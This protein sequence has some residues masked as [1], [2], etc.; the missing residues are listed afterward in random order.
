MKWDN[1]RTG[2]LILFLLPV[3]FGSLFYALKIGVFQISNEELLSFFYYYIFDVHTLE[4]DA[5]MN[6]FQYDVIMELRLP[7][8]IMAVIAGAGLAAGGVVM[9]ALVRNP[10]ADP[11]VLGVSSGA[12][13]GA[14]MGIVLGSFAFFGSFAVSVGAFLGAL[15]SVVLVFVLSFGGGRNTSVKMVL[16]GMAVNAIFGAGTSL[17]VYLAK[18]AEGIRNAVFWM[19]GSLS[20]ASWDLIPVAA[21]ITVV[22]CLLFCTQFRVLNAS[23]LGDEMAGIL[24]I[25][26]LT[27]RK[28][29]LFI[30]SLQV[31]VLVS[32]TG[33]IGFVGL[34][35]PHIVRML[36]GANHSR[37]L[38]LS[39]LLGAI[40]MIWC[41]VIARTALFQAELPI[42][43]ITA[44]IGGPLFLYLLLSKRYGF[45][46]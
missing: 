16:A 21:T 14:A 37:V 15:L 36:W 38:P 45:G 41:D 32:C 18:D 3:L 1:V 46:D 35:I 29:L 12:A 20:A 34:V 22:S 23:L 42:G 11:Y 27:I 25:D 6:S 39:M 13:L 17:I 10:L 8:V 26:L 40:F 24:G 43:I 5:L 30:V 4:A 7:R 28:V 33:I 2:L 44:L 19:M 31:S 9:Q